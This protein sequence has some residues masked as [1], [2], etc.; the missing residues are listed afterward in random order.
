L[1]NFEWLEGY[2]VRFGLH[3]VDYQT[4]NRTPK[5]SASFYKKVIARNAL[6]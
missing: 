5:L 1:D 4:L 2:A 3:Y 6:V